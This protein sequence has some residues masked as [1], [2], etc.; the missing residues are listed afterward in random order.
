MTKKQYLGIE[1][2]GTKLQVVLGDGEGHIFRRFTYAVDKAHGGDGIRRRIAET[3]LEINTENI[4]AAGV[5]YGGPVDRLTGR[6]I[7]SHQA[8]GWSDFP[9]KD[10]LSELSAAPVFVDNDCNVAALGEACLGA[11]RGFQNVF[12]ITL[13]SGVGGGLV[14][15][16]KIYNGAFPGETEIGHLRLDKT[17]RTVESSCSG[18]AVDRKITNAASA[19]PGGLLANLIRHEGP[20]AVHLA[21]ALQLGDPAAMRIL[22]E[23]CDDLAFGISHVVH[24]IHPE[25]IVLG[26]GLSLIGEPLQAL[27]AQKLTGYVMDVFNTG[28]PI[29]LSSLQIDAVPVG[30]L[31]LAA[32]CIL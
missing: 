23:T 24:L 14:V 21:E 16:G 6:T 20:P 26:G 27:V 5:G 28:P 1:I 29:R 12:F 18:W 3:L 15:D 32:T 9:L 22:D 10:W 7:V 4:D 30:A 2:G 25:I 31:L 19:E 17:G 8:S 13:G 11:G